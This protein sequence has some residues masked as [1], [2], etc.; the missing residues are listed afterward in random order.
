[1]LQSWKNQP[2]IQ[3]RYTAYMI[4]QMEQDLQEL[5][6]T[7]TSEGEITWGMRQIAYELVEL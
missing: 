1:M 6:E 4:D 3:Q 2:F 5:S 7:S